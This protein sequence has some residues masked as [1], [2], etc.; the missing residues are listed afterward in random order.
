VRPEQEQRH[1]RL[2][3]VGITTL[4]VV[5]MIAA[6]VA[7][8]LGA[9]MLV[10]QTRW[11]GERLRRQVVSRVN[12]QI[13]G[14]L[15][16][17]RLSFGGDRLIV[18]DVSLRDPDG[19]EVAEV[20]RAEVDFH[21]LR[22]L[23]E[24]VRVS[25]VVLESPR[26]LV[27]SD[28]EG[29]NLSRALAP[30]QKAPAKAKPNPR[31]HTADDGWVLRLDRFD[32]RDGAVLVTSS[33]GS[34][35]RETVRL[36]ALQSFMSVRYA[37]GNG[38]TDLVFR[39]DGRSVLAPVGPL[40]MK[41]EARVRGTQTQFTFDGQ[42]LGGTVLVRGDVDSQHLAGADALVAIDIPR[43]E[44]GGYGWGPLRVNG[45]ARPGA[46]PTLDLALAIPGLELTAKGGAQGT[47]VFKLD[48]RLAVDDL[49]RTGKAAQALTPAAVPPMAGHGDFRLTVQG[50]LAGAPAGLNAGW[51]GLFNH[52]RLGESTITDLSIDGHAAQLAAIPGEFDLT[53][54]AASASSGTTKLGKLELAA[55]LRQQAI[56][57]SA[58]LASPEAIRMA[59]AGH[60]DD[61]RQ[62]LMLSKLSL[63]YPKV[64]WV[65]EGTAHL[66]SEGQ[67]VSL[68]GLRLRAQDNTQDQRLAVDA[69]KDDER[70]DAH[71]ALTKFRLDLLPTLVAP[72]DLNL[73]GTVDL[74]VKAA[75]EP[76]DPKVVARVA[77]ADGRFRTF[78]RIGASIDATLADQEVDG[79][80]TFRAP[81]T[82]MN[83]AF[84]LPADPLEGGALNLR[85]AV[86]RLD[87]AEA[88]QAAQSKAA[89]GGRPA[90]GGHPEVGGRMT[91]RLHVTGTVRDP[92]VAAT[93]DGHDLN[94]KR[95]A[96]AAEGPNTIDMGHASIRLKYEDRAAHADIDFASAHG[97]ELRVDVAARVNLAYPAVTKGIDAKK[98]PVHGKVMAKDFDV[99]WLARFNEQVESLGGKVSADAKVA[100]TVGDPQFIG[101]VRWKHGK[102]VAID[103][104][105]AAAGR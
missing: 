104:R 25:A 40:A 21:I 34:R 37:L 66:R 80:L 60:V 95:P 55:K 79:T 58:S 19:R 51:K 83:G 88:L 30:R 41:A 89:A 17:G 35:H 10:L 9:T 57:L 78:S 54:A 48:S 59:L 16:I 52:L 49:A 62:G 67:K 56:S 63:S 69:S 105:K 23:R 53:V 26:L 97:G 27:E 93:V 84:H 86:E 44:V 64:E 90:V 94:V 2:R 70:V 72:R 24:E 82:E 15:A 33:D 85:L 13:Q 103:P 42:L 32:L 101:D 98:I 77:L 102:V 12:H 6:V 28:S 96:N 92:R 81:F 31:P 3:R 11:G 47:D 20:A 75:G 39:L 14:G 91:A 99:A 43:T 36:E 7:V 45:Q 61:D 1:V 73:G 65:S 50:P 8:L 87:L 18:W 5:G 74:D 71:V 100:G 4:R 68:S 38:S 76:N 22:L 29:S 46:I